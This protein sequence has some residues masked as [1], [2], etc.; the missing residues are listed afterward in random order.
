MDFL[1]RDEALKDVIIMTASNSSEIAIFGRIGNDWNLLSV[2]EDFQPALPLSKID[3]DDSGPI[4]I[5][6]D[7]SV[8]LS[9]NEHIH[10]AALW[11]PLLLLLSTDGVLSVY[12]IESTPRHEK[13]S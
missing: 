1:C 12:T 2:S 9:E 8:T 6:I 3:N 11:H 4:G 7:R 10:V 13:F 5:S